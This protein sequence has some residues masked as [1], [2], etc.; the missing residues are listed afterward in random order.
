MGKK[1][2]KKNQKYSSTYY[3]T[4]SIQS[5]LVIDRKDAVVLF[6]VSSMESDGLYQT[7]KHFNIKEDGDGNEYVELYTYGEHKKLMYAV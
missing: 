2:F 7:E 6:S 1:K 3:F 4:G 5:F